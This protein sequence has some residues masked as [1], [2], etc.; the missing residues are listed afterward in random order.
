MSVAVK[1][2]PHVPPSSLRTGIE[3]RI[4][5]RNNV[6]TTSTSGLAPTYL[7]ANL[8]ILPS[9]YVSDFRL[10]CARNPVPCAL[11]AESA[12]VGSWDTVRSWVDGLGDSSI[13][14][15]LDI[16]QDAPKYMVYKDGKLIKSGCPDIVDEWTEDHVA[17]LIGCSF[18]FEASLTKAGFPPRHT[19]LNRTVP[20]YRTCIPLC[21]AGVFDEGNYVV[22]MRPYPRKA[23]ETVR[24][25]CRPFTATHGEP[26]AWGWEAV[27]RLGIRDINAPEW[28]MSPL[29]SDGGPFGDAKDV[30]SLLRKRS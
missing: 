4:A 27:E 16:R 29:S 10:L 22:S 28:G 1:H 30:E 24:S 21:P 20:M 25:I 17:F 12:S 9:V 5:S 26:I 23:I 3:A 14:S 19:L 2:L 7:Q 15:G 8:I 13:V 18:S 6:L 11:I